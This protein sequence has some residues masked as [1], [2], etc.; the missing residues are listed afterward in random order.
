MRIFAFSVTVFV[1][2]L[3]ASGCVYKVEIPT[4][5]PIKLDFSK[6]LETCEK[7]EAEQAIPADALEKKI[8][9]TDRIESQDVQTL[10]CD[11]NVISL[12]PRSTRTFEAVVT[13]QP[14]SEALDGLNYIE[15]E[16]RRTCASRRGG[17]SDK[18]LSEEAPAAAKILASEI[19]SAPIADRK[20][21]GQLPVSDSKSILVHRLN[22][23]DGLN[24]IE[25]R[26]YG[27]CIEYRAEQDRVPGLGDL[28]NC[29]KAELLATKISVI[30]LKVERPQI[31]GVKQVVECA[32]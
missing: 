9:L 22:I 2:G 6:V 10:D 16:N 24:T 29:L 12:K 32:R 4:A 13:L 20:G 14:P 11:G 15:V 7:T 3:T 21:F 8:V 27:K 31:S 23:A 5:K 18:F 30:D 19:P 26:Y 1:C 17:V 28:A 25:V